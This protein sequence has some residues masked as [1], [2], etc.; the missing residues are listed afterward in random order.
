MR[1]GSNTRRVAAMLHSFLLG[2]AI[3][4][5][6]PSCWAICVTSARD[7]DYLGNSAAFAVG[8]TRHKRG[9]CGVTNASASHQQLWPSTLYLPE[10]SLRRIE[11]SN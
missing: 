9:L 3:T 4:P 10:R 2:G 5:G 11:G 8:S 1:H 6:K 7:A